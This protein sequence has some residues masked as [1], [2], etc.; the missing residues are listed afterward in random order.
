[1]GSANLENILKLWPI[2]LSEVQLHQLLA[3]CEKDITVPLQKS[4]PEPQAVTT[5]RITLSES[6]QIEKGGTWFKNEAFQ[7]SIGSSI[8]KAGLAIECTTLHHTILLQPI[9]IFPLMSSYDNDGEIL[10]Y[11]L[12]F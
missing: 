2:S 9:E 11:R 6:I 7:A 3:D 10:V 4:V 8:V 12:L 5:A 1:M